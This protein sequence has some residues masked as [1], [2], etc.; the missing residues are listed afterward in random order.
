LGIGRLSIS[1]ITAVQQFLVSIS[2]VGIDYLNNQIFQFA[3]S[4]TIDT[5]WNCRAFMESQL[6]ALKEKNPQL[7]VVTQLVRGQHPN[8]KGIYSKIFLSC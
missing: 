1:S 2:V 6:P 7:E 4:F 3:C 8:L 5:P